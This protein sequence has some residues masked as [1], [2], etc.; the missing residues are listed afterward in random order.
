MLWP[1]GTAWRD[2]P[3][4]PYRASATFA[5]STRPWQTLLYYII[6]EQRTACGPYHVGHEVSD[7][8]KV[9]RVH[10]NSICSKHRSHF[11]HQSCPGSLNTIHVQGAAHVVGGDVVHID[12]VTVGPDAGEVDAVCLD[13]G[14]A[15]GVSL[16]NVAPL[17]ACVTLVTM[18]T[19][20]K[21]VTAVARTKQTLLLPT[22]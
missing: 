9:A 19:A 13:L 6:D 8:A 10:S 16:H 2:A 11:P 4:A 14:G 7:Q 12:Q 20:E 15:S 1:S 21:H 18:T 3:Y 17:D 22:R 5:L